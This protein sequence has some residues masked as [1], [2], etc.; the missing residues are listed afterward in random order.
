MSTLIQKAAGSVALVM[1]VVRKPEFSRKNAQITHEVL[2]KK[3]A[4]AD[5]GVFTTRLFSKQDLAGVT[6]GAGAVRS[7]LRS[8][9]V[10]WGDSGMYCVPVTT[11]GGVMSEL[12]NKERSYMSEVATLLQE[13]PV[14]RA[15][16]KIRQGDAWDE[17]LFPTRERM[18]TAFGVSIDVMPLPTNSI[19]GVTDPQA[20]EEIH[21]AAVAGMEARYIDAIMAAIDSVTKA[22][23][24][25]SKA[26][27]PDAQRFY[28]SHIDHVRQSADMLRGFAAVFDDPA[29][30]S[31]MVDLDILIDQMGDA[32][33]MRSSEAHK[34]LTGLRA[35][36]VLKSVEDMRASFGGI[37]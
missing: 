13:Y 3:H 6:R 25:L 30:R 10:Q 11:L 17:S 2:T 29:T 15:Q 33:K 5:A 24:N 27:S 28:A 8:V 18:Q 35:S 32:D 37:L 14:I 31:A 22:L 9:G 4:S 1:A 36:D 12:R 16:A 26:C 21:D 20:L 23:Q 7:Y 34:E 19:V